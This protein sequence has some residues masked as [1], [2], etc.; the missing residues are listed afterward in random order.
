MVRRGYRGPVKAVI[1]DWAG[2]TVDYGCFAPVEAFQHAFEQAGVPISIPQARGPMGL[3]KQDHIRT[4]LRTDA[5]TRAWE[6]AH[7]R[8]PAEA[9]VHALYRDAQAAL[10]GTILS[11]AELIPGTLELAAELRAQ[12]IPLG[13]TTGYPR[14][15]ME[16]LLPRVR[17]QGYEPDSLVCPDQVPAGR[18]FPWMA[19]QNLMNLG[20]Y[21]AEAVVKIGDTVPD[22]QEGLNA[23]MWTVG[24]VQT[25]NEVGLR[26]DEIAGLDPADYRARCEHAAQKLARAGAHF[27][28]NSVGDAG[29]VIREINERLARGQRA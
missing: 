26:P 17:A 10:S 16:E 8:A 25:G 4:I 14:A 18:P 24:V 27:V 15:L 22:I 23:G 28:V 6:A 7:G 13:S 21:P 3:A 20:V 5:V 11:N 1:L 9:D 29:D 12:G 19:F 2:T